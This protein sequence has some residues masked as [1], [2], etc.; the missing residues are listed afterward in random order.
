MILTAI[1]ALTLLPSAMMEAQQN[2]FVPE[3]PGMTWSTEVAAPGYVHVEAGLLMERAGFTPE[4]ADGELGGGEVYQHT[5]LK[6]PALMLRI[7]VSEHMEFRLSSQYMRLSWRFDPNFFT[8]TNSVQPINENSNSGFTALSVGI[9]SSL[10]RENGWIPGSALIASL[11]LPST[12]SRVYGINQPAPD[13]A[14]SFSHTLS[15]NLHLGYCTGLSWDGWTAYPLG[16]GST[17]LTI[18]LDDKMDMF[19]EYAFEA[20]TSSPV[21]HSADAGLVF[22]VNENF[23]IDAWG[24]FGI[25]QPEI[26]SSSPHYTSIYRSDLYIGAGAAYRIKL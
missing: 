20:N 14:L 6:L 10:T 7:G 12:A 9:K 15:K 17:M 3:R 8:P 24:G 16:Y 2:I 23:K 26:S 13:L 19:I 25:G 4:R 11:A 18:T 5:R 1:A 21:L 22:T